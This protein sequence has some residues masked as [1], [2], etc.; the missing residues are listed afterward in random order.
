MDYLVEIIYMNNTTTTIAAIVVILMSAMLVIAGGGTTNSFAYQK[1]G[2]VENSKNGNTITIQKHNQDG[3]QSGYD[4]LFEEEGQNVICTHP[5]DNATCTEEGITSAATPTSIPSPTTGTLLVK[6]VVVCADLPCRVI[7][8]PKPSDFT[9]TVTD[10]NPK[11]S[12]FSGS[13]SGTLVTLGPGTYVVKETVPHDHFEVFPG[14][15]G[16]CKSEFGRSFAM[17]TIA[18]GDEKTCT[19]TNVVVAR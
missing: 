4:G 19:I 14:F 12:T 3:A 13:E 15:S 18:A 1:R 11:P 16:D 5:N 10:N 17:G 8:L 7:P 9:I 2:G 6:K